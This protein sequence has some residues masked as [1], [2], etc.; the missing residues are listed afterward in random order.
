ME[1]DRLAE[2]KAELTIKLDGLEKVKRMAKTRLENYRKT[3]DDAVKD[4]IGVKE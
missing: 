4:N 3:F 2:T 1:K